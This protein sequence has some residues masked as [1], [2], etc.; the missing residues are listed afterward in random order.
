MKVFAN[1]KRAAS[2]CIFTNASGEI[3]I[4][5][6]FYKP[7]WGLPGG[8]IDKGEG[9]FRACIREVKEEVDLDITQPKLICIDYC[10]S[11]LGDESYQFIYSGGQLSESQIAKI[12]YADGEIIDHRFVTVG[13]SLKLF[14]KRMA[15]RMPQCIQA[16]KTGQTI[17]LENGELV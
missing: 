6:P 12:K 10:Q 5:K 15:A 1:K 2:A 9:P 7:S 17:Y 13:E 8:R 16:I 3:L 14:S 11:K 4:I